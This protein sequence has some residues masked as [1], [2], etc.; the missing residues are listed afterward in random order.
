MGFLIWVILGL[1]VLIIYY[2]IGSA[3]LVMLFGYACLI[4]FILFKIYTP[5][6]LLTPKC[7]KSFPN[8]LI[9]GLTYTIINNAILVIVFAIVGGVSNF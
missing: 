1:V 6:F 2:V 5:L 7:K 3:L 8:S 9:A 4:Y